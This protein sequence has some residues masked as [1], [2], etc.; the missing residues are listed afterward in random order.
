MEA[1][2]LLQ[3]KLGYTFKE[4]KLLKKAVTHKSYVNETSDGLKHNERFEF[5]GDSVLDLI[6]SDFMVRKYSAYREGTLSKIRAAVVN[7]TCLAGL[8]RK[9]DLGAFLLLGRGEE[10]SGGRDKS[11]LLANAYEAVAGAIY[12]DSNLE[13]AANVLLPQLQIEI[14]KFADN[15]TTRDYKSD[16]Q[17]YTQNKFF[18]IP[19]YKVT[20]ETGPDHEK[21]FEIAASVKDIIM[22]KGMGRSKKE[23]EQAAAKVALEK[24]HKQGTTPQ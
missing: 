18:C 3:E 9:L 10:M 23:A 5:L 7:E 21:K 24:Y 22:G 19:V 16:L 11:S 2:A 14:N 15:R 1:L 6:V 20:R 4:I 17:E 13:T 12:F 8:A